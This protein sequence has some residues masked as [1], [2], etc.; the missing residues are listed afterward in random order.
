MRSCLAKTTRA[1]W[2]SVLA[3]VCLLCAG[4][5]FAPGWQ[6]AKAPPR[7]APAKTAPKKTAPKKK[8][9]PKKSAPKAAARPSG[10]ALRPASRRPNE[11]ELAALVRAFREAP[12]PARRAAIETYAAAH[13]KDTTGALA[14][15]GLG[16]ALYED[17]DFQSAALALAPAV[18]KLKPIA[19]YAGYYLAAARV[20]ML[21]F[22]TVPK[23]LEAA[24]SADPR[25]PLA[26]RSWLL[27]ARA[28][29]SDKPAEAVRIMRAHYAELPQP[30][31]DLV[32]ADAYQAARELPLAADF[33]QRVY[34]SYIVGD[35]SARAEL[36]LRALEDSMG[37]AYPRPL[38]QQKLRR[39]GR[40]MDAGDY[41]RARAEYETLANTLTGAYREQAQVRVGATR[42]LEGN[43][44]QGAAYLR[45]LDPQEPEAAAERLYYLVEA[46]RRL[47]DDRTMMDAL[48]RL[49]EFRDSP[50][51]L[52]GLFTAANRFL[53]V[54]QTDKF[55]PL[56]QAIADDFPRDPVA[57]VANWKVTFRAY[58]QG[59]DDAEDRLKE[60]LRRY[61][62][63][64]TTGAAL[65][66]LGR[67]AERDDDF[68][69]ARA[70]Y[71]RLATTFQNHYYAML[72]RQRLAL[73]PV[74]SAPLSGETTQFV[75]G[76]ELAGGNPVPTET[77]RATTERIERSR[78]LREAGLADLADGELRFGARTGG[79]APLL[80][81]EMA[82]EAEEP[83][84]A[85][86]AM[87]SLAPEYLS[88]TFEQAP[89]RYWEYLFPLSYRY[90]LES[91]ARRQG[92]D[93]FLLA[94][95]IRQESEFNP[96]AVSSARAYGLTQVRPGTGREFARQ[97]G[98][99]GFSTS[100]LYQPAANLK[101]GAAILRSM[102]DRNQGRVEQTLASY[103][104]GPQRAAEWETWGTW[105][106]PA[107][108]IESIPFTETRDY[109]QAVLRN[110]DVYRRLYR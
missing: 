21:E 72:A 87:K 34:Y 78:L 9:A 44:S 91:A 59:S 81:L 106:E 53:L 65:Y 63:H 110:A 22:G 86:R 80:A 101:I 26:A 92:V 20:E 7:K 61:P 70:C 24:R 3:A 99:S 90:E 95:L 50:W 82:E 51:R 13:A 47:G 6:R 88:L 77:E 33:Y 5:G 12:N 17:K 73:A 4:A 45:A 104:A 71:R 66:F 14:R 85:L 75:S 25:S 79:Q 93:P 64:A 108:F 43:P 67:A 56:Y 100:V 46:G 35:P 8:S 54:N 55:L 37:A 84:R 16:V 107:E 31:G 1:R 18:S 32:L 94:G 11:S 10:P 62:K 23:L 89:R 83:F 76:L 109:V 52:K 15:L 98:V 29:Q 68:S 102:L 74:A 30:E 40:L 58:L 69:S 19:D 97:A 36:A 38:P 49:D 42:L 96:L 28:L 2:F 103:N 48:Q 105:R 39:A 60:H 27:E 41:S 57:G